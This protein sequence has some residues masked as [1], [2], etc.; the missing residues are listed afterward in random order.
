MIGV[1]PYTHYRLMHRLRLDCNIVY[2]RRLNKNEWNEID[3][4]E[5]R[6][7]PRSRQVFMTQ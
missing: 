5:S 4:V 1:F 3:L 7:F 2:H 6:A